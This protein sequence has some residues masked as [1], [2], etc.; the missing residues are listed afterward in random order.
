MVGHLGRILFRHNL[1]KQCPFRM[2][3]FF[4]AL[5]EVALVALAILANEYLGLRIRQIL[6]PLLGL[7][8]ELDPEPLS[9]VVDEAECVAAEQ[10]HVSIGERYPALAHGN[11]DLM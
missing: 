6:D 8:M 1:H 3:T 11:R 5:V 4:D 7:E 9:L 2:V 10:V